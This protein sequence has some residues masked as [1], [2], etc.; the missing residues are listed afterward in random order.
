MGSGKS[1]VGALLAGRLGWDFVAL[2]A[3]VENRA[4]CPIT[5]LFAAR[6]EEGFRML[7][8]E[9]LREAA[10]R[11]SVVIASG[12]GTPVG[13]ANRWFF[14]AVG[15]VVFHLFVSLNEALAR[16]S[17]DAS[18]PLLAQGTEEV[19][20]L[21]ETRLPRYRSLGVDIVTDGIAPEDVAAE[22]AARLSVGGGTSRG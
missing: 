16:T 21:Y 2:D 14:D 10:R 9:C 11:T 22:I 17:G 18:R 19:R 8:S 1:T 4:G 7:E 20:R 5:A 13:D 3:L 6:G 12:G 15:T